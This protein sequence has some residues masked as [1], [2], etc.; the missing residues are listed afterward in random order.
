MDSLHIFVNYIYKYTPIKYFSVCT[1]MPKLHTLLYHCPIPEGRVGC[2]AGG[3]DGR[4]EDG[5]LGSKEREMQNLN[6]FVHWKL[7]KKEQRQEDLREECPL[8][9]SPLR[10]KQVREK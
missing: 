1:N 5:K 6:I 8:A 4:P 3:G 9:Q 2:F 10:D 7:V